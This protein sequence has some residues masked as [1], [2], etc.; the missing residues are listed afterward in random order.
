M[1]ASLYKETITS[2]GVKYRYYFSPAQPSRPTLLLC[3]GFPSTSHDWWHLA[4]LLQAKGYGVIAPDMLGY[5]GTDKPTDPA[6]Y[7]PSLISRDIVDVL[8]AEKLGKVIAIGHDWGAKAV[9]R[10]A[11]HYP[12]RCIAY[13]FFALPFVPILPPMEFSAF[14]DLAKA[15]AGHDTFGYWL[16]FSDADVDAVMQAHIES[17]ASLL[18]PQD[19]ETW[20]TR[21]APV[22]A[23]KQTLLD[24]WTA[25]RAAYVSEEDVRLWVE[26]FRRNGFDAPTCWYKVMT[27]QLS[28]KDDQQIPPERAVPPTDAPIFFAAAAKDY[29]CTPQSGYSVFA[30]DPFSGHDIMKKEYDGDHWIILSHATDI[31]KDLGVW[32]ENTVIPKTKL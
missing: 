13:A 32:I 28:A 10:L 19:P 6:A 3:H 29:I 18:Y 22:G 30:T 31:A 5:G 17:F 1:D 12:E 25:P 11:N 7:V 20:Q 8:D 24:D 2:R 15:Q 9:S 21:I 14:L 23:L 26:T 4:P 16:F 27:T